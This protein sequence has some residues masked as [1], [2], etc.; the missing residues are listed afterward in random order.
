MM[1][2]LISAALSWLG[3][4]MAARWLA[5]KAVAYALVV[6][7]LPVVLWNLGVDWIE[8]VLNW[9]IGQLPAD[10]FIADLSGLAGWFAVQLKLTQAVQVIVN[11]L[12]VRLVLGLV[13]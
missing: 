8:A 10:S 12:V 3:V 13:V 7:I 5:A 2:G 11:A 1:G 9:A 4:S 6:V